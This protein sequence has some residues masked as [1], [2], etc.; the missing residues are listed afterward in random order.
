MLT[1]KEIISAVLLWLH[2]GI[3]PLIGIGPMEACRN[4]QV[5]LSAP[6]AATKRAPAE[7]PRVRRQ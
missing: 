6:G 3:G 5:R 1:G 7:R 2:V 4:R